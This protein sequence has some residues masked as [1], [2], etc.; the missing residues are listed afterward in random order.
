VFRAVAQV[1]ASA[2]GGVDVA[3]VQVEIMGFD[4]D[5]VDWRV[6][7][8]T[9]ELL[10]AQ[11]NG[12]ADWTD[13]DAHRVISAIG[14]G[15]GKD[16]RPLGLASEGKP[17]VTMRPG[18]AILV[19]DP[20]RGLSIVLASELSGVATEHADL[21]QLPLVADLGKATTSARDH[22][23]MH[24]RGAACITA[25]G[26]ALVATATFDSDEPTT[27]ALLEAGCS[28]VVALDRGS[29]HQAF[30]HRTGSGSPP[31]SRYEE[32]TLY[33]LGRP[34]PPRAFRWS[35]GGA[36]AAAGEGRGGPSKGAAARAEAPSAAEG[37]N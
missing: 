19:A 25:T 8:G 14:L 31:V 11:S 34:M 26:R 37:Q 7:P 23:S 10:R 20:E 18:E 6:R 22:G 2:P 4:V 28:R 36:V 17:L 13:E 27:E 15:N 30:V 24:R 9:K 21:A 29:H 1:G 12:A 32:T 16:P 35:S 3:N 5:R 33:A